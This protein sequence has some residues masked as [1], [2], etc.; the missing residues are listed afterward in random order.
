[1]ILAP[2]FGGIARFDAL[3]LLF[4]NYMNH[5]ARSSISLGSHILMGML[6]ND[7]ENQKEEWL[8]RQWPN[9]RNLNPEQTYNTRK[10]LRQVPSFNKDRDHGS[11]FRLFRYCYYN[12]IIKII[13]Y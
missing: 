4:N 10:H 2:Y 1:M 3:S 13:L 12:L 5:W 8:P 6:R 11:I 7:P 9:E